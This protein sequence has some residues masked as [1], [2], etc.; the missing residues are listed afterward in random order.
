MVS[1]AEGV[2]QGPAARR[3]S[4]R[5][6]PYAEGRIELAVPPVL[7]VLGRQPTLDAELAVLAGR[8]PETALSFSSSSAALGSGG[9]TKWTTSPVFSATRTA[10]FAGASRPSSA[11]ASGAA[12][13]AS[14]ARSASSVR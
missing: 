14:R 11:S 2:R 4:R 1:R 6:R 12:R 13:D 10:T 5:G 8:P 7:T 3:A 9:K